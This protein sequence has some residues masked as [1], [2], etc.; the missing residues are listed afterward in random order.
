MYPEAGNLAVIEIEVFQIAGNELPKDPVED[1]LCNNLVGSY[2][3]T[4][5]CLTRLHDQGYLQEKRRK[6]FDLRN[7]KLSRISL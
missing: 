3:N 1:L 2:E 7:A 5:I 4:L 6:E